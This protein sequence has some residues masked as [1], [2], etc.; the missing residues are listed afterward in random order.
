MRRKIKR[1]IL[2]IIETINL[3]LIGLLLGIV[4]GYCLCCI[5]NYLPPF[6]QPKMIQIEQK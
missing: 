6:G 3:L 4:F 1:Q 5:N 2:F